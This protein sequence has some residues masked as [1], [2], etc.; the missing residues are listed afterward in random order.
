MLL[1]F[2]MVLL[3]CAGNVSGERDRQT[4]LL[5][6]T[7]KNGKGKTLTAKYLAGAASAAVLTILFQLTSLGA[8][9]FRG[10]LL[11]FNQPV[12]ALEQLRLFPIP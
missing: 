8:I 5:L 3:T 7:A 11:G 6:H 10:G 2:L 1:V 4:W 9:L 12:A